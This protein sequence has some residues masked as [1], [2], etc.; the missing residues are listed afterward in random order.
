MPFFLTHSSY[1][2]NPLISVPIKRSHGLNF[3]GEKTVIKCQKCRK[4]EK[5]LLN[6]TE[7][8]EIYRFMKNL[9]P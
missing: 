1:P 9:A 8:I 5:V 3:F 7:R 4:N 2:L 6:H